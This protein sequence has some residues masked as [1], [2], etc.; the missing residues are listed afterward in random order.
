[1]NFTNCLFFYLPLSVCLG[2]PYLRATRRLPF[3][4]L[5]HWCV[6]EDTSPFSGLLHLPLIHTLSYWMLSKVES[7]TVFWVFGMTRPGIETQSPGSLANTI[8]LFNV[9]IWNIFYKLQ[10]LIFSF[11]WSKYLILFL[12]SFKHFCR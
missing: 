7:S 12:L 11:I 6:V 2:W 8:V 3:Q 9:I 10:N 4:L 5:L 1:M